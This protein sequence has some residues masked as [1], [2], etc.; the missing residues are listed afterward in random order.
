MSDFVRA[1]TSVGPSSSCANW[2]S[3]SRYAARPE[4]AAVAIFD[5]IE[6]TRSENRVDNV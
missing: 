3:D 2:G 5:V 6:Y 4:T 1:A